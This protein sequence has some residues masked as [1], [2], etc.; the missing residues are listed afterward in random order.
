ME[1]SSSPFTSSNAAH[2]DDIDAKQADC[3]RGTCKKSLR[4][5]GRRLEEQHFRIVWKRISLSGEQSLYLFMVDDRHAV[6]EEVC[7]QLYHTRIS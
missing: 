1:T 3:D 4:R 2:C 7:V 6:S 5:S